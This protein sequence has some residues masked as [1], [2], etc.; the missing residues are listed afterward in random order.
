MGG[1]AGMTVLHRLRNYARAYQDCITGD[2]LKGANDRERYSV[3]YRE[4][5]RKLQFVIR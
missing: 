4:A 3:L 1:G 5:Q 2:Y